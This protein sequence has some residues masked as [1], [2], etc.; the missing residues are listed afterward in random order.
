MSSEDAIWSARAAL[1]GHINAA[2]VSGDMLFAKDLPMPLKRVQVAVRDVFRCH[3]EHL[4]K[5]PSTTGTPPTSPSTTPCGPSTATGAWRHGRSCRSG[6]PT[7]GGRP[8]DS[9]DPAWRCGGQSGTRRR[10]TRVPPRSPAGRPA[11]LRRPRGPGSAGPTA[12]PAG[13]GRRVW[14]RSQLED[15]ALAELDT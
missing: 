5:S 11:S 2:L 4:T 8:A 14:S 13:T 15:L 12:E 9:C 10:S 6:T 3:V 7:A 1:V